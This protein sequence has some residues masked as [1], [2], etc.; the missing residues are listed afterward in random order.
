VLVGGE[1]IEQPGGAAFDLQILEILGAQEALV[2]SVLKKAQHRLPV[3]GHVEQADRLAMQAELL[4]GE[5]LEQLVERPAA[6]R[7]GDNRVGQL[8]HQRLAL[9]HGL[10]HVQLGAT[11]MGNLMLYQPVGD[12]ADHRA[13]A[14]QRSV[15]QRSHQ[16]HPRAAIDDLEVACREQPA[17]L[18][19]G[20][21]VLGFPARAR[22]A[23]N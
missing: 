16:A 1:A 4:P 19:G 2:D 9:V 18:G 20:R 10:D 12:H 13:A 14:G 5:Q 6:A 11:G 17:E 3:A 15:G 7:Q 21:R 22:A 8:G 23:E